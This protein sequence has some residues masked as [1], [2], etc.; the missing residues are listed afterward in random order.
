MI[1]YLNHKL[2]KLNWRVIG[3]VIGYVLVAEGCLMVL[4]VIVDLIYQEHKGHIYLIVLAI[5]LVVGLLLSRLKVKHNAYFAKDG[6]IAVGLAWIVVSFF[7]GLPFYLTGEFKSLVD[8]FFEA[9]SGFTTTGSSILTEVES[10]SHATL[11]WRS[12]THWI[13]GMG[14]LV[15][16]LALLPRSNDRNMHIMR[17]EAPGPTIGKLVPRLRQTAMI[18][19]TMYMG[20]T[21]LQIIFLL[22]GGM[23][24]FDTLCNTF[25]TAGT[26][27]FAIKNTSIGAYHNAYYEGVITVFMILFGINFNMYYFLFI[28]DFKSV[29]KNEEL[30]TYLGIIVVSIVCITLNILSIY[31]GNV[32]TSFRY[33]SFQ[34]GSIITTTGYS[35]ID[36]SVWP[37]FSRMIIFLLTVV[38]ASAGSTGGGVKVSRILIIVKKI[39]LDIQKLIHPQKVEAITM[40]GKVVDSDIVNQIMAY[41]CCFIMIVGACLFLVSL[42]NFDFETTVTAVITCIG[43]VGPGF[44]LCGPMG[45]FSMFSD[46]SKIVLSFAMLIGRLEIYPIIIFLFPFFRIGSLPKILNK[47]KKRS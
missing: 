28:R 19:Y 46:F 38:G 31:H 2:H 37:T 3:N 13:G 27:G 40:D 17:A 24:L 18:L 8:A 41:F 39:K 10:L 11:F 45:N 30:R 7:G 5:C 1:Y 9:V 22:I 35:S 47:R 34:V 43:N 33:A 23:P 32:A 4:P 26:G 21:V 14:I 12:F 42:N 25:G 36:Y 15:F 20:L 16:I 44:G 6:M 29:F